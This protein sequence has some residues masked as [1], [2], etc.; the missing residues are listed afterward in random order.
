MRVI[1]ELVAVLVAVGL[2]IL[3]PPA[4]P[5]RW[6]RLRSGFRAL[7]ANT[8]LAVSLIGLLVL[9]IEASVG[10]LVQMPTPGNT[11]EFPYLLAGDTFAHG[12]LTNPTH[13]LWE[14]FES[15]NII[16]QPSYQAK[17]PPGQGLV[18]ALGQL[19][20]GEPCVGVWLS[21]A[22]AC[23]AVGWMLYGWLPRR[24]ALFGGLLT[25]LNV[26]LLR[27]WGQSYWGGAVPLLGG[28]L[29]FGA[30]P[31]LVRHWRPTHALVLGLGLTML[32]LS[33]PY[34]GLVAAL[35]AAGLLLVRMV[36]HGWPWRWEL[37]R[38]VVAPLATV[39]LLA[40]GWLGYYNYRVTGHP[41]RLPY[42]VWQATYTT[43]GGLSDIF[44]CWRVRTIPEH[45][46]ERIIRKPPTE[47]MWHQWF[48]VTANFGRK[49]FWQ[50]SFYVSLT[51]TPV[52]VAWVWRW[53][54]RETR[55]A[56]FTV[57][58]VLAA[59]VLQN[60]HAYPH[61]LAPVACLVSLLL[62]QGFRRLRCWR[63]EGKPVGRFLARE[64]I[65]IH[66]C[67]CLF[68]QGW[69][70][71]HDPFFEY[72]RWSV[73]RTQLAA[74]LAQRGDK[75]VVLVRY[76]ASD[77]QTVVWDEWVYNRADID[78]AAVIWARDLGPEKNRRLFEYYRDRRLWVLDIEQTQLRP[79][80]PAVP[81]LATSPET[82]LT[83]ELDLTERSSPVTRP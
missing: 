83:H 76:P 9:L 15:Y 23:G 41:L 39:L 33:R 10:C 40:A 19:L 12:R 18:L 13:P 52:L 80:A 75:H 3:A 46:P 5:F 48:G 37:W 50:W 73:A 2:A 4:A 66:V 8:W 79:V 51:L 14:H 1:L 30:L 49:L 29:V 17:Y 69:Q 57:A 6:R 28:A 58:L 36:R 7:A 53:P 25:V 43:Y 55:F 38:C 62:V 20:C 68:L 71:I 31:R 32:A 44:F 64:L 54:R 82:L 77:Y 61:Y 72:N 27:H 26:A 21:L 47:Q 24:W 34:E 11:D 56:G 67:S 78:S 45:L 65:V 22:A 60:T 74:E 42:A 70:W 35:P 16:H 81:Q 63:R 59:I